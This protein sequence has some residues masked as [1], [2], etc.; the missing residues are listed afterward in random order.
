MYVYYI[1]KMIFW[2]YCS[3]YPIWYFSVVHFFSCW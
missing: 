3:S 1:K 2:Q